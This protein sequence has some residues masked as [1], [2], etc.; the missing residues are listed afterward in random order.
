VVVP[1]L[2]HLLPAHTF[3]NATIAE[4]LLFTRLKIDEVMQDYCDTRLRMTPC[5]TEFRSKVGLPYCRIIT[6]ETIVRRRQP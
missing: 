6:L 4:S 1:P 2:K 3:N 5:R